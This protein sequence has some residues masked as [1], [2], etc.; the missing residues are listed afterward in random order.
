MDLGK[1]LRIGRALRRLTQSALAEACSELLVKQGEK[2]ISRAYIS[3]IEKGKKRG[4]LPLEW[5]AA[6]VF[7]MSHTAFSQLCLQAGDKEFQTGP[8][9]HRLGEIVYAAITEDTCADENEISSGIRVSGHTL[10]NITGHDS[11][12]LWELQADY[13]RLRDLEDECVFVGGNDDVLDA[14]HD[15]IGLALPNKI[16]KT[17]QDLIDGLKVLEEFFSK[18]PRGQGFMDS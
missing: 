10:V 2:P 6:K 18:S 5:V 12:S 16:L 15:L 17:R 1:G 9:S 7:R 8:E 4:S 11:M 14:A 3:Q 13:C